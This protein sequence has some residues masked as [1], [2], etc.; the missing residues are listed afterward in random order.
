M[1]ENLHGFA[2]GFAAA[3]V[4]LLSCSPP[5]VAQSICPPGGVDSHRVILSDPGL[6]RVSIPKGARYAYVIGIAGG[7]GGGSALVNGA[8]GENT[9][10]DG[11]VIARGAPGANGLR[12][13]GA[14][15]VVTAG[16]VGS[17]ASPPDGVINASARNAEDGQSVDSTSSPLLA[18][19]ISGPAVIPGGTAIVDPEP[20]R[21]SDGGGG[22]ASSCGAGGL[23]GSGNSVSGNKPAPGAY[24]AGGGGG[25]GSSRRDGGSGGFGS[26]A[27]DR[28]I[29]LTHH[30][31]PDLLVKIGKGGRG[32]PEVNGKIAQ[33]GD[34]A[35]GY[36]V[37]LFFTEPVE[38]SSGS[39]AAK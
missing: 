16:G 14:R 10:V 19:G 11:I 38:P 17:Q 31:T 35:N 37:I 9:T 28:L 22:G 32:A 5:S 30:A 2:F 1:N 13:E 6:Y 20:F 7:G 3:G 23:A 24:G 39:P 21:R 29:D 34:G 26:V 25:F 12:L 33:S 15:N 27:Q 36:A 8:D 18:A 4:L